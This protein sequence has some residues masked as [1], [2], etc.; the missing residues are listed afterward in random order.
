MGG[1]YVGFV[2]GYVGMSVRIDRLGTTDARVHVKVLLLE[3]EALMKI[4][5]TPL[6]TE[7]TPLMLFAF[8]TTDDMVSKAGMRNP[9]VVLDEEI[10]VKL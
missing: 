6:S 7:I 2:G 10:I 4:L 8:E 3:Y 9:K 1:T 5:K